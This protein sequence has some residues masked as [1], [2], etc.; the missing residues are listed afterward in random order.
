MEQPL[1]RRQIEIGAHRQAR[2]IDVAAAIAAIE[3]V[4]FGMMERVL[5]TPAQE[6]REGTQAAQ[7]AN[8]GVGPAG[9]EKRA[10]A[11]VV[12]DNEDPHH[13]RARGYGECQGEPDRN[14]EGEMHRH[15]SCQER[16][17]RR[18]ELD[19]APPGNRPCERAGRAAQLDI[20]RGRGGLRLHRSPHGIR[21]SRA[22]SPSKTC[23][24]WALRARM[25]ETI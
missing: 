25:Q 15:T 2:R 9:C 23:C 4:P 18:D 19:D 20:G 13:E 22:P 11:A 3:I 17:K 10:V 12:L 5:A 8:E 1:S 14:A 16:T 24:I 21:S 7:P 6:G